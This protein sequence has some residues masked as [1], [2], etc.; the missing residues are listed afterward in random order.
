M[1]KGS[2][3]QAAEPNK[4]WNPWLGVFIAALVLFGSQIL[5]G[6]I[7]S[8][9]PAIVGWSKSRSLNWLNNSILAQFIFILMAETMIVVA[10]YFF[11]K[12]Y[13]GGFKSIGIRK[14]KFIDPLYG[15]AGFPVY[16]IIYLVVVGIVTKLAPH[17]NVNEKQQLG[18]NSV[19]GGPELILTFISLVILPP[20]GEEIIFRGVLY[21][22]LKKVLPMWGAVIG[23]CAL[24][25]AG[26]LPEGGSSGPLYIAAIDTFSLSLVLIY[27]REKT[28]GLY[29]SMTLHGFK[30]LIAFL[31]LYAHLFT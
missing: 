30:N 9:Y 29:S 6:I 21:T 25:A 28:G 31:A 23:T 27:L 17:L 22:S 13:K 12:H 10:I 14:P 11:V 7:L 15:I 24:F 3:K 18:F 16:L 26:H 19:H 8:L 4:L 20:I 1:S 5:S 2:D